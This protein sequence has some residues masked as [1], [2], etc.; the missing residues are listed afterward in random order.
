MCLYLSNIENVAGLLTWVTWDSIG[1]PWVS[2]SPLWLR[3]R[4]NW[5]IYNPAKSPGPALPRSQK[6]S[7]H[8]WVE[9]DN[10]TKLQGWSGPVGAG[11]RAPVHSQWR[12]ALAP[13]VLSVLSPFSPRQLN[14]ARYRS[15]S[16]G[17]PSW[18]SW[19]TGCTNQLLFSPGRNWEPGVISLITWHC[20]GGQNSGERM[21]WI[22]LPAFVSL[23]LCLSQVQEPIN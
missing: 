16:S 7:Y 19:G 20:A 8:P 21:S 11:A 23:L 18:K 6:T 5:E 9:G 12:G 17:K 22:S 15:Q 14:C 13:N 10:F 1:L 3:D 4:I 2:G